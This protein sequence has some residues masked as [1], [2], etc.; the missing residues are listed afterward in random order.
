MFHLTLLIGIVI[1]FFYVL[2]FSDLSN[3]IASGRLFCKIDAVNGIVYCLGQDKRN[4]EYNKI[5]HNGDQ[6]ISK[7]QKL[8]RIVGF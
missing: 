3:F 5:I 7:M 1:V 4:V 2:I 6:L 8:G